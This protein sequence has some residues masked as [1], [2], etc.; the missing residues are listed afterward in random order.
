VELSEGTRLGPYEI[1]ARLGGGPA[2]RVYHARDTQ[3]GRDVA[4]K[5][6]LRGLP[7]SSKRREK[8]EHDIRAAIRLQH[9]HIRALYDLESRRGVEFL[10]MEYVEGETLAARLE[11]G[12]LSI[13]DALGIAIQMAEALGAAHAHGV[14]HGGLKPTNILLTD[15]GVRVLDFGQSAA[16]EPIPL[17]GEAPGYPAPSQAADGEIFASALGCTAPEQIEGQDAD[18]K[19]DIFAFGAILYEMASGR[20]AF[21]GMSSPGVIAAVLGSEPPS[22]ASLRPE[23]PAA[24]DRLVRA[25]LAKDPD[26]RL[27]SAHDLEV[28]LKWIRDR[29]SVA[30]APAAGNDHRRS[31]E[32]LAWWTAIGALVLAVGMIIAYTLRPARHLPEPML[33]AVIKLPEHFELSP[34][35]ASIAFSPSGTTLAVVGSRGDERPRLWLRAAEGAEWQP[36][37]GTE[38]ASFPFWSPDGG[39]I[40][41]FANHM[42]ERI[43]LSSGTVLTIC[44]APG[45]RGGTWNEQGTIVFA[46]VPS[47]GLYRVPAAG[48]TPI[49]VSVPASAAISHRLPHF[50]PGGRRLLFLAKMNGPSEQKGIYVLDVETGQTRL[51]LHGDGEARY[52]E[53]GFLAFLRK[54]NLMVQSFSAAGLQFR[55]QPITV[56]RD[57]RATEGGAGEFSFSK[58]GLL[59]YQADTRRPLTQLTWF[60]PEG[61]EL[62]TVGKPAEFAS[63]AVSPDGHWAAV[64]VEDEGSNSPIWIYGLEKGVR[65][66]LTPAKGSFADPVWSPDGSQ[67]AYDDGTAN[68]YRRAAIGASEALKLP[69][70]REAKPTAWSPDGRLMAVDVPGNNGLDIWILPARGEQKPYPLL[71][72]PYNESGGTFSA[73]G[74]WF[75]YMSDESGV[76]QLY[77]IPFPGGG[78]PQQIS[79]IGVVTGG[80][81]PGRPALAYETP[82]GRLFAVDMRT[83]GKTIEVGKPR[84]LLG[85]HRVEADVKI[86][87]LRCFTPGGKR[88]L[89]PVPVP[90]NTE[91]GT[92][93][94][95][96][97]NWQAALEGK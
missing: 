7:D 21:P 87:G 30:G 51:L 6:L 26:E 79:T 9:P 69:F 84:Q 18:A 47:G 56:A 46:P 8:L 91:T 76:K 55:G 59:L 96:V 13:H 36:L 65:R 81:V 62:G 1:L 37:A 22:I 72:S 57:V 66:R 40:A 75:S 77:V 60:S 52:V 74:R 39:S 12:P 10:V 34:G 53:P 24:L 70:G 19:S 11:K 3:R 45:G 44:A 82:G 95:L 35:G 67:V 73:D 4:I 28:E 97:T 23:T 43:D 50:L 25:C 17:A 16:R 94:T 48:G 83:R 61:K 71:S 27:Q 86:G 78:T 49:Q 68:L 15:S 42:L 93:L 2:S 64:K 33:R 89:L 32:R 38:G 85:G 90:G 54:G 80:W 88:L 14:I 31:V 41:F 58:A 29:I 5:V 92:L 63:M 20:K